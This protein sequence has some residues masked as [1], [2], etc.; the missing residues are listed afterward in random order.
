MDSANSDGARRP[1]LKTWSAFGNLGRRP[2]EYEVVTHK[3]NHTLR[4]TPLEIGP[5]SHGNLWLSQRRDGAKLAVKDWDSFRDPDQLTYRKYVTSQDNSETYLDAV[6]QEFDRLG[7]AETAPDFL[8]TCMTP[9]RY[10]AHGLQMLSGY[11]QQ[12]APST[13]V[14]N[15]AAFQTADHLRRVQR[16]AYRTKQLDLAYPERLFGRTERAAWEQAPEWQGLRKGIE[17]LLVAFDWDDVFVGLNLVV[18]PLADELT[19]R[20]FAVVAGHL[21]AELDALVA[22]NLFLDAERSRRWTAAL[23]RFAIAEGSA[24]RERL[25]TLLVKWRP[26]AG[27]IIETG[28]RMLGSFSAGLSSAD[29]I[30]VAALGAWRSFLDEAGLQTEAAEC[31]DGNATVS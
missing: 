13:Y 4:E 17:R 12:L 29:Q 19:L 30:E 25:D 26:L 6:L 10:L 7:R 18:K 20:Q 14:G 21:D 22:N 1:P 9:S 16:V 31:S 27:E 3:M 11:L 15:C 5:D 24:S 8:Q 2:S 23:T 28:S